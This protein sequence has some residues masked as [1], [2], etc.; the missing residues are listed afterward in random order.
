MS[1]TVNVVICRMQQT[2]IEVADDFDGSP[3]DGASVKLTDVQRA[4]LA[5]ARPFDETVTN[6]RFE[7]A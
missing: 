2:T 6:I 7:D 4:V 3:A 1:R 5:E